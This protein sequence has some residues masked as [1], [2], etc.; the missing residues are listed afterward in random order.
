[1]PT[2]RITLRSALR[3]AAERSLEQGWVC[4]K[5]QSTP[6]LDSECLVVFDETVSQPLADAAGFSELAVETADL[7]DSAE[8]AT[9]FEEAPSDILLLESFLYYWRFDAWLPYP[10]ALARRTD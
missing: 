9:Q 2:L 4:L 5:N 10:G 3:R 8:W 1:M 6:E 7:E